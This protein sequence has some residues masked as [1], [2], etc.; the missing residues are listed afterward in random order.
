MRACKS[1]F[2]LIELLV[3]VAIIAVLLALLM[4][5]LDQAVYQAELAVCGTRLNGVASGALGYAVDYKRQYPYRKGVFNCAKGWWLA[6][7]LTDPDYY[8]GLNNGVGV[9][10]AWGSDP[11]ARIDDRPMLMPYI[12]LKLLVDPLSPS[13]DLSLEASPNLSYIVASYDLRFSW[14]F[15]AESPMSKLGSR[16]TFGGQSFSI[17]AS[18]RDRC[19]RNNNVLTTHPDRKD[20]LVPQLGINGS[21]GGWTITRWIAPVYPIGGTID[22]GEL[23]MNFAYD[24]GSVRRFNNIGLADPPIPGPQDRFAPIPS[25]SHLYAGPGFELDEW[26]STPRE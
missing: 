4:P 18:D 21:A 15:A 2:T 7:E 23:D 6:K 3:V 20:Y 8:R 10:T 13:L 16:W 11:N 1:A 5:A 19:S 24:D 22:R 12:P 25:Y 9:G 17:L 14:K 26:Q